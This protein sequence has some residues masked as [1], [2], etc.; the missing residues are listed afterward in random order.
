MRREATERQMRQALL[1]EGAEPLEN[2]AGTA[3]GFFLDARGMRIV[4]FPGPPSELEAVAGADL[5]GLARALPGAGREAAL[6]RLDAFGIPEPDV[7]ARLDGARAVPGVTVGT[8]ATGGTVGV[9]LAARGPDAAARLVE[10]AR[11]VRGALGEAVYGEGGASLAEVAARLF[12]AR[13]ITVATAESCTGGLVG[14]LLT[15]VPGVSAAYR[16]GVI[17]YSDEAKVSLLGV[18]AALI[19][20]KGAVSEEVAR[21]MASGAARAARADLGIGITGIAGPSGGTP[22][23][24]VGLVHVAADFRGRAEALRLQVGSMRREWVKR[25]SALTA[26]DLA[27][28]MVLREH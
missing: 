27:R 14:H 24:P 22:E 18:P 19:A 28:R 20:E 13:G 9:V 4:A 17:A 16:G 23:K 6:L 5:R 3:A 7:D 11:S 10:A 25:R 21:A 12:V 2:P 1:P 15:D 26:L 8:L